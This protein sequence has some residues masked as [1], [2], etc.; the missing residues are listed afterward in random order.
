[1]DYTSVQVG[2]VVPGS[3][4]SP[5]WRVRNILL[6]IERRRWLT[7]AA[8]TWRPPTSSLTLHSSPT[9]TDTSTHCDPDARYIPWPTGGWSRSPGTT[10]RSRYTVT[11]PPTRRAIR[12]ADPFH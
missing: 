5:W 4:R 9:P 6:G 7:R 8:W 10:R 2:V 12:W 3:G 1:M 11:R